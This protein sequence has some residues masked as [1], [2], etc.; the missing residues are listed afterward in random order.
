MIRKFTSGQVIAD[1]ALGAREIRVVANSGKSDRVKDVLVAKGCQLDNYRTNNIVLANHDQ[2]HPIGNFEPSI[3]GD[4]VEGVITFAPAGVSAKAD[5]Y[6]GLYKS[7]VMKTVSVGFSPVD[8][9]PIA[10]GGTRYKQWELQEISCVAVPCD[11]GAI[12]TARNLEMA[13]MQTKR[14]DALP[15]VMWKSRASLTLPIHRR[16]DAVPAADEA[17]DAG[18][19]AGRI[20]EAAGFDDG[21]PDPSW[22]RKAFLVYDASA[23]KQKSSYRH[24]IADVVDG[25][26]AVNPAAIEEASAVLSDPDIPADIKQLAAMALAAYDSRDGV[27]AYRYEQKTG[28]VLSQDNADHL[29]GAQKCLDKAFVL[30]QQLQGLQDHIGEAAEHVKSV[31]ERNAKPQADPDDNPDDSDQELAFEVERRKRMAA[32]LRLSAP[33]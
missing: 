1:A 3:K 18:A 33:I 31:R 2:N 27:N 32:V 22:A 9:E 14:V 4:A 12:V 20:F 23:P 8:A 21:R 19:A 16:L 10:G 5:E 25:R 11:P 6:C 28:R 24:P 26:L 15:A 13:E 29:D 7:G 30:T 17:W